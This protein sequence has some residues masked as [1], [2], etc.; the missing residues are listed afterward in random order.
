MFLY[1][2]AFH[3]VFVVTW[4]AAL[5]YMPRLFIYTTEAN[6][7]PD[8]DKRKLLVD[9]FK[10]M[11][12]RLWY[13]IAWPSCVITVL[14][15]GTLFF[16]YPT[17]PL[18]LWIKLGMVVLLLLYHFANDKLFREQAR[19]QFT[20]SSKKLRI[21]NEMAAILLIAIVLLAVVKDGINYTYYFTGLGI[22]FVF[23]IILILRLNS[24]KN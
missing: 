16:M 11:Q 21:W 13:G 17:I 22:F 14:M 12:R 9:Q 10:I 18:W 7:Q 23:L 3:I 24:K 19:D 1:V 8:S 5:F 20:V 2:K 4:F 15:G 6:D